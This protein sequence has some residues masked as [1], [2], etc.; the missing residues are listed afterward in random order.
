MELGDKARLVPAIGT[1]VKI[2]D[3][4]ELKG[5]E[6]TNRTMVTIQYDDGQKV[7]N[8]EELEVVTQE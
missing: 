1:V 4:K 7:Y 6:P 8:V 2:V 3:T 5:G